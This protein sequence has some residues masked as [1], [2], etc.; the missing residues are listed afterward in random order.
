[1]TTRAHSGNRGRLA[2]VALSTALVTALA[3]GAATSSAAVVMVGTT[4]QTLQKVGWVAVTPIDGLEL[5]YWTGLWLGV[6]PTWE[7]V[8]A[9]AAAATFVVGSYIA[10]EH[11]RKRRRARLVVSTASVSTVAEAEAR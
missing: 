6:F 10:A 9:Q 1:M 8:L 3:L 4:V 5:P 7:G 2:L 11:V